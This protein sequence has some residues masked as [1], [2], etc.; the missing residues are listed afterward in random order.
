MYPGVFNTG[1]GRISILV[2]GCFKGA[3]E[4]N[5]VRCE[6]MVS[7]GSEKVPAFN[8]RGA[9]FLDYELQVHLWMRA[10]RT[11]ASGRASALM[12][13]M[14]PAHVKFVWLTVMTFWP[15]VMAWARSW[16]FRENNPAPEAADAI[17][18]EVMRYMRLKRT[19]QSIAKN[20][21][22]YNLL[23][24]KAEPKWKWGLDSR[25]RSYQFCAWI[26]LPYRI[27]RSRW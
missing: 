10:T 20:A 15:A 26:M 8:G 14:H 2:A 1:S 23:R 4:P 24:R 12:P 25:S 21:A 3:W 18:Q 16:R 7:H 19:E 11:E 5:T 27:T 22:E 17:H 9:T 6:R 13:H